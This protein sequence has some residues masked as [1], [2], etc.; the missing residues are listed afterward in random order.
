MKNNLLDEM[1]CD[2]AEVYHI[3]DFR[4]VPVRLWAT[5]LFG[6]GENSRVMKAYNKQQLPLNTMLLASMIDSLNKLVWLQ[7]RDSQKGRNRPKSVLEMLMD[8]GKKDNNIQGFTSA[9]EF[10]KEKE[11]LLKEG[12]RP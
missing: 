4:V 10:E 9:E 3:Y 2:F 8:K 11:R 1:I 7:T 6:L 12:S 5:L